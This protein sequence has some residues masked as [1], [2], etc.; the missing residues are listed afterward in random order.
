MK[1][2]QLQHAKNHLSEVV[3]N[4][5]HEGPQAITLHGIPTAVVISFEAYTKTVNVRKLAEPLSSFF[6]N[7]PLRNAGIDL[8]RSKDTGRNEV[9]G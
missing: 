3:R 5:L 9:I 4:A 7:S 2:W 6:Q 1:T 8:K